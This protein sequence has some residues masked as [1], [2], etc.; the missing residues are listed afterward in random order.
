MKQNYSKGEVINVNLGTPPK[1]V[2]GHEQ[3]MERPCV[4]I[5]AFNNLNLA[6]LTARLHY[7]GSLLHW[8]I[9]VTFKL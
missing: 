1:E 5:R 8:K 6:Q 9:S 4:V 2:K 3:G 7:A